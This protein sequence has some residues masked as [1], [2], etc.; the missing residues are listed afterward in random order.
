M[1]SANSVDSELLILLH[2]AHC[3]GVDLAAAGAADDEEGA[4]TDDGGPEARGLFKY[5]EISFHYYSTR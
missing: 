1:P 5:D 3:A 4:G 2:D